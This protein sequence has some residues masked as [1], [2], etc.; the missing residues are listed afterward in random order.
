MAAY[1]YSEEV[2]EKGFAF[3]EILRKNDFDAVADKSSIR[4]Y[5]IKITIQKDDLDI[6][7]LRIYYKP[8]KKSYTI[9]MTEMK[10][11]RWN[12]IIRSLWEG[13]PVSEIV[14]LKEKSTTEADSDIEA[15]VD[16]SFLN[17]KIGYGVVVVLKDRMLAELSGE[18]NE[19]GA[20]EQRQ[21]PGEI[22]AVKQVVNWAILNDVSSMVIHYDYMGLEKWAKGIWKT[23]T[24]I[25]R[26]YAEF[27]KNVEVKIKWN[28]VKSHSGNKWNDHADILAKMA[29]ESDDK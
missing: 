15:Y 5:M 4:D 21:I 25:T 17:G 12:E 14:Q 19:P 22:E 16:G 13:K 8:S 26:R 7:K 18:C 9:D 24:E 10:E 6:G 3:A 29:T 2:S 11:S 27:M 20:L 1:K 23:N 28:K